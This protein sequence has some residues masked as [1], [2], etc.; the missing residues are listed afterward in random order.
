MNIIR[1]INHIPADYAGCVATIGNFDGLHRGHQQ[2]LT[3]LKHAA[4]TRN[5][6][7]TVISF[8]PLP[9]EF[10]IRGSHSARIYPLR[11]K[12]RL[13]AKWGINDFI[14]FKFN[15]SFSQIEAEDFVLDILLK[16]L[17]VRYLVVG[18]D[19]CFGKKRQG[20]FQLLQKLGKQHGMV[21]QDTKTVNADQQRISSTIIRK[22]LCQGDLGQINQLLGHRYQLS[23]RIRQGDKIGRTLN[24][25]TV[26]LRLPDNIALRCGIYA[27]KIQ[28]LNNRTYY[29]AASVGKRPTV[30][31]TDMR[32]E[33]YIFDFDQ[34]VYGQYICIEPLHFIR[35]EENFESID[36]MQTQ[37]YQD[38]EDIKIWIS[39]TQP[40]DKDS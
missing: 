32:L 12:A 26:N 14:Q 8:D 4:Q 15:Q 5:L 40:I 18:D 3:Q 22:A 9:H 38:C 27:V 37:I 10:F 20:N 34:Q 17:K 13:L 30:K 35:P 29:G 7:A 19:F 6:A 21:V 28:G 25:P 23:G 36:I 2:V 16:R 1:G 24:F 33:T 39:K 11:D 31:G